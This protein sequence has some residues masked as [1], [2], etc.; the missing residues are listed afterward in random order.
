MINISVI[1]KCKCDKEYE[2]IQPFS[3]KVSLKEQRKS[4]AKDKVEKSGINHYLE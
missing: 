2:R 3:L 4:K 1:L